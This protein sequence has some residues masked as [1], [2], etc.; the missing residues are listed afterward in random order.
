M[1]SGV[2]VL[3]L[4]AVGFV[5]IALASLKARTLKIP[6]DFWFLYIVIL[7]TGLEV[8]E[9]VYIETREAWLLG[10]LYAF[11]NNLLAVPLAI[12][13]LHFLI[14]PHALVEGLRH[15]IV[16]RLKKQVSREE[17]RRNILSARFLG[18]IM[19][20]FSAPSLILNYPSLLARMLHALE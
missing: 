7:L 6:A 19:L 14:R 3:L 11:S 13:G 2:F 12:G 10:D 20:L 17:E 15:S 5:W 1:L 16:S 4:S 8:P 18:V 9:L